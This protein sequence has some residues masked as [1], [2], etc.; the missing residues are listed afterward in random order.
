VV[1]AVLATLALQ[2][3]LGASGSPLLG[4]VV[5]LPMPWIVGP[6]LRTRDRR[7][8]VASFVLGILWDAVVEEPVI[9]PGGIAWSAAAVVAWWLSGTIADRGP[10]MWFVTGVVATSTT[11]LA[12]AASLAPLGLASMPALGPTGVTAITTGALCAVVGWLFD[13]DLPQR[14]RRYRS[15]RL[16]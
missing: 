14:W 9:G 12:R 4:A 15:R 16:H 7:W 1:L 8:F 11:L 13:A 6:A 2:R 3:A 5:L 10:R